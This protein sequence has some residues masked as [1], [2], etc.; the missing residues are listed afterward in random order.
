MRKITKVM[1]DVLTA[2]GY[3]RKCAKG[4]KIGKTAGGEDAKTARQGTFKAG[5]LGYEGP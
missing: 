4:S 3:Q 2:Q 1:R 5:W